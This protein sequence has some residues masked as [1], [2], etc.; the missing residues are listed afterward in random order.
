[1]KPGDKVTA[2]NGKKITCP[3]FCDCWQEFSQLLESTQE[4]TLTVLKNGKPRQIK[5]KKEKIF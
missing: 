5:I 1:M 4:V 3:D 2:I